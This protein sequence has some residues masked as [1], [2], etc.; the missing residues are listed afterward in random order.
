MSYKRWLNDSSGV[1][2]INHEKRQEA[3][4]GCGVGVMP[5][6][7]NTEISGSSRAS[8]LSF[9]DVGDAFILR[10]LVLPVDKY[11]RLPCKHVKYITIMKLK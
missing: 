4:G 8:A 11:L 6:D 1:Q 7:S 9:S 2:V 5:W 10:N 3:T